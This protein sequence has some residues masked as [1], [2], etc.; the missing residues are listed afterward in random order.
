[1]ISNN[2]KYFLAKGKN[3]YY[4]I[5]QQVSSSSYRRFPAFL[6][7][8]ILFAYPGIIFA[9]NLKL[10]SA[11]EYRLQG[12]D[13]QQKANF[14]QAI[15]YYKKSLSLDPDNAVTLNDIAVVYEQMGLDVEAESFYQKAIRSDK[16]YL[17]PYMNLAYLYQTKGDLKKAA[18][19]FK[20][21]F[22]RSQGKDPWGEKARLELLKINEYDPDAQK[23]RIE[24]EAQKLEAEIVKQSQDEFSKQIIRSENHYKKGLKFAQK[25]SLDQALEEFNRALSLTPQNPK[26]LKAK[27]DIEKQKIFKEV[28]DR[29]K[30]A[31]TK[32]NS[33]ETQ[34]AKEEFRRILTIIPDESANESK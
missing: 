15:S 17:P 32:L 7:L 14:D 16:N 24:E 10:E 30:E 11:E 31:V 6:F 26:I 12:Y 34:S 23:K 33:G 2:L 1:M 8:S 3:I 19:Y 18:E 25:K 13:Q 29:S 27:E 5:V 4:A 21:R 22:K 20:E 28:H 9:D